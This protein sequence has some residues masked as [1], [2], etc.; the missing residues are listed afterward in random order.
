[1]TGPFPVVGVAAEFAHAFR[2]GAHQVDI[3]IPLIDEYQELVALKKRA[4]LT[5]QVVCRIGIA[6]IDGR[7]D[8]L[9]F[10]GPL[11]SAQPLQGIFHLRGDVFNFHQ[12]VGIQAPG[13]YLFL[14][15]PGIESV[16]QVIMLH[17]AG[18]SDRLVPAMMVRKD[19]PLVAHDLAGTTAA[20]NNDGVLDGSLIDAIELRCGELKPF[21][22]HVIIDLLAQQERKPHAFIGKH[23]KQKGGQHYRQKKLFWH[24]VNFCSNKPTAKTNIS[25]DAGQDYLT[26]FTSTS[27]TSRVLA[28]ISKLCSELSLKLRM[29]SVSLPCG[30]A[31]AISNF[32]SNF[33]SE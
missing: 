7:D 33:L 1:M 21:F 19:Q 29:V 22:Y 15:A 2:R 12:E 13:R 27:S 20:E 31:S 4:Y 24:N 8:A 28:L 16:M 18:G 5:H 11:R 26:S 9:R 3:A 6:G 25:I 23:A 14:F 32:L 17:G 10:G 30:T